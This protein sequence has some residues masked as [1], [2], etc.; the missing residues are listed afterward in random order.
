MEMF[1]VIT[2]ECIL[3]FFIQQVENVQAIMHW[4]EKTK[5]KAEETRLKLENYWHLKKNRLK[6]KKFSVQWNWFIVRSFVMFE[7]LETIDFSHLFENVG[8]YVRFFNICANWTTK[9]FGKK[10]ILTISTHVVYTWA[11]DFQKRTS[12]S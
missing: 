1:I 8:L 11:F 4:V 3:V 7:F 10:F 6:W 9:H 5:K 2:P 12:T